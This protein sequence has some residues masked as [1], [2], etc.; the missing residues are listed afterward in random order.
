MSK[1]SARLML[2]LVSAALAG[3]LVAQAPAPAL[4]AGE[5]AAPAVRREVLERY[6]GRYELNG[7]V[8]TVGVT[9][10]GRLTAQLAGQ[11]P[12]PPLRTVSANEFVADAVGV[13]LF[14][15]GEGPRATRI[16]SQYA[17]SE[18]IGTR[19]PDGAA[20]A[21]SVPLP[22]VNEALAAYASTADAVE[23][24]DG[25]MLNF[26]CMG[27]GSPTVIPTAGMGN[28]SYGV[29]VR[30]AAGDGADDAGL[31]VGPSRLRAQRWIAGEANGRHHH[32]RP[33]GGA[34]RRH[35]PRPVR[36]GGTLARRVREP[37]VRRSPPQQGRRDGA[38]RSEHSD[39]Q[40]AVE[41]AGLGSPDRGEGNPVRRIRQCAADLREGR[42]KPGGADPN[43]CFVH[44]PFM[45]ARPRR[46]ADGED[47]RM[48]IQF[49]DDG[50][51]YWPASPRTRR[52]SSIPRAATAT[53]RWSCSTAAALR[54]AFATR[55][56]Q[57]SEQI[58]AG[59]ASSRNGTRGTTSLPRCPRAGSA[60]GFRAQIMRSRE[61]RPQ[62]VIDAV[63]AVVGEARA[64]K[65]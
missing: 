18:V 13:R 33:R 3:P 47:R 45:P 65:P 55:P 46:G 29:L 26:V 17:G 20:A 50:L 41:R 44:P 16:R 5:T 60:R 52:S 14:F 42:I 21:V 31:R 64:G 43:R 56:A 40:A 54:A 36:D 35:D 6:V 39:Q 49:Q 38:D 2:L 37:D 15:E 32:G 25:R 10:D 11:P 9:E 22:P 27:Q 48:P 4:V 24:P 61:T 51:V 58:R 23:L 62:V 30:R 53:C 1:L 28:V 19:I 57:L 34:D 59:T 7:T 12:G 63:E 8:V